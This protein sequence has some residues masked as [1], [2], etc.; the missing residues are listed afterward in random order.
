M[1]VERVPEPGNHE[2]EAPARLAAAL[3]LAEAALKSTEGAHARIQ[4]VA[5]TLPELAS[6]AQAARDG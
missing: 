5:E 6:A 2:G 3:D 4:A 1:A